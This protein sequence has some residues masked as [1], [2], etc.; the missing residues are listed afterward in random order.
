MSRPI[1]NRNTVSLH[2]S[3][4]TVS[5]LLL[6]ILLALTAWQLN[7]LNR[8]W[9]LN[10]L[11][12]NPATIDTDNSNLPAEVIFAK[13]HYLNQQGQYQQALR[14]YLQLENTGDRNFRTKVQYNMGAIYLQQAAKLWHA[15]GV[16]EYGPIN[17]LLDLAERSLREVLSRQPQNWRARFN[18]EYA[19]RIRPPAKEVEKADWQGH[20]SSVHAIM[21]GI[22]EGGP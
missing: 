15:K 9:Q 20:K 6:A 22:P 2:G 13:A 3:H 18:L 16:W 5:W 7:A 1:A 21:P 11:I 10:A 8:L 14:L 4:P 17:T 12:E 19:L